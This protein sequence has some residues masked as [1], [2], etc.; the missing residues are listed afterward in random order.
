[1]SSLNMALLSIRLTVGHWGPKLHNRLPYLG[2]GTTRLAP[3]VVLWLLQYTKHRLPPATRPL[4][5]LWFLITRP[6]NCRGFNDYQHSLYSEYE[7]MISHKYIPYTM[8]H[9]PH[10][11]PLCLGP[12]TLRLKE[13]ARRGGGGR[14]GGR[15]L[16]SLPRRR[17]GRGGVRSAASWRR[18][19]LRTTM[20]VYVFIYNIS[21]YVYI[22][23][24][25]YP[26]TSIC[27]YVEA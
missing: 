26:H 23:M 7:T 14:G 4:P 8:Y 24:Y 25:V 15:L 16:S 11:D 10:Y 6:L 21:V 9:I 18:T 17:H 20:Y 19:T 3:A 27:V 5:F 12:C 2:H 13:R 1:M 22:Y